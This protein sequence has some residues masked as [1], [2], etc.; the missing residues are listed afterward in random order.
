MGKRLQ[1]KL[2]TYKDIRLEDYE[3]LSKSHREAL[4]RLG[5]YSMLGRAG[6]ETNVVQ[7][8]MDKDAKEIESITE[9][10]EVLFSPY[11]TLDFI[12][13]NDA[14]N[15]QL[16]PYTASQKNQQSAVLK[17]YAKRIIKKNV[18]EL[19]YNT[20]I[21]QNLMTEDTDNFIRNIMQLVQREKSTEQIV[22]ILVEE[23]REDN[24][25]EFYPLVETLFRIIGV[26]CRKSRDGVNAERWDAMI[27]DAH[28]SIPIEIKSPGEEENVS[29]KAIRQALENKIVLLSRKTYITDCQTSSFVVGYKAPNDRAEVAELIQNIKETYGYK[30]AVFDIASLFLMAVNIIVNKKGINIEKLYGLEGIVNVKDIDC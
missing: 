21:N 27:R 16:T 22:K 29:I 10:K 25:G 7:A 2:K 12:T 5:T 11:Q 26:D 1:K 28:K 4:I 18:V 14:L 8:E 9:G 15:L 17:T 19:D 13:V 30:I 3:K 24:K 20:A 23:H 6:F